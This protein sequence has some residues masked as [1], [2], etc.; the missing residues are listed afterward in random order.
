MIRTVGAYEAAGAAGIHIEDQVAPKKCGHM[1]GKLVIPRE[2][3]AAKIQA[4]TE[5]RADPEFAIIART[6]SRAVEGFEQAMARA[7]RYLQA[8]ADAPFIEALTK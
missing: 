5:A 7:R 3:M 1:D 6:D 2:E 8:G 4:A